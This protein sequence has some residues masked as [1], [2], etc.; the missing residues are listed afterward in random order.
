MNVCIHP[1]ERPEE[2]S[3]LLLTLLAQAAVPDL[4]KPLQSAPEPRSD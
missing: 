2:F 1:P 4:L 3:L